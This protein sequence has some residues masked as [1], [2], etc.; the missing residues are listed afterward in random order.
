[1]SYVNIQKWNLRL[2]FR[3]LVLIKKGNSMGLWIHLF[4]GLIKIQDKIKDHADQEEWQGRGVIYH[5]YGT[6]AFST[7][8]KCI[9]L[10]FMEEKRY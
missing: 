8:T 3:N 2:A 5:V 1:M 7:H 6:L 10:F 4:L 9:I